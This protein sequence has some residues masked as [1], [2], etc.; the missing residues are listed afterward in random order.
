MT[1]QA[2]PYVGAGGTVVQLFDG[3]KHYRPPTWGYKVMLSWDEMGSALTQL[4]A[5]VSY[6]NTENAA[7]NDVNLYVHQ[8]N[9]GDTSPV[10]DANKVIQKVIPELDE[11]VIQA[12]FDKRFRSKSG[13]LILHTKDNDGATPHDWLTD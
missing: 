8:T 1:I 9:T 12:I 5:A 3:T 6:L 2:V 11:N 10:F 13:S 7:G 4:D